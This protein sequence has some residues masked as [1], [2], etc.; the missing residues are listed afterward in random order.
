MKRINDKTSIF[1]LKYVFFFAVVCLFS[2]GIATREQVKADTYQD[3]SGN[4]ENFY[5]TYTDRKMVFFPLDEVDGKIYFGSRGKTAASSV[6]TKFREI[7]WQ[8]VFTNTKTKETG[9]IYYE[10]GGD[11]ITEP[12]D[13]R[14][15]SS[16]GYTYTMYYIK[17]S[18]LKKRLS[19]NWAE[20]FKAGEVELVV[21]S[22]M[23]IVV[24][25]VLKGSMDDYGNFSGKVYTTYDGIAGAA[26]WSV[27]AKDSLH[28][29]FGKT[30]DGLFH[31]VKIINGNGIA[32]TS[33]AGTYLY[34]TKITVKSTPQVGWQWNAD[35]NSKWVSTDSTFS[36]KRQNAFYTVGS[37]DV[38]LVVQ[39][40]KNQYTICY[41]DGGTVSSVKQVV[42]Y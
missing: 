15:K 40:S 16:D 1:F 36:S 18:N 13:L 2:I 22:V 7:G 3:F 32:S 20:A 11:F 30:I 14:V 34:G 33:G 27:G 10:R 31:T 4:A 23:T 24:N 42:N 37:K 35:R 19:S 6:G 26:G 8:F 12:Q 38:T 21:N 41:Q 39:A 28:S 17:L 9:V 25:G 29:Y 5:D